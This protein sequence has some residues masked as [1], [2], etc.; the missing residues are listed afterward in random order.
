MKSE[1]LSLLKPYENIF[2]KPQTTHIEAYITGIIACEI[3]SITRMSEVHTKS[4]SSFNRF[5][6]ESPWDMEDAKFVFHK[7]I[8]P[9]INK[10]STLLIDDTNS[11]RPYAKKVEKANYHFDHASG[12]DVLGYNIVTSV[13]SSNEETIPY[14]LIHY[15]RA[16]DCTDRKFKTKNQIA[17][18]IINSTASN[19][20]ISL[21]IFDAW[22]SNEIVIGACKKA[23]KRLHYPN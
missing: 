16:Q 10:G 6:T 15:Y 4:R 22:Y 19:R 5:L 2:S 18:E 11:K 3:P 23:K 21:V 20:N 9:F 12:K 17:S 8:Q 14:N 13:I 7:Q 1:M